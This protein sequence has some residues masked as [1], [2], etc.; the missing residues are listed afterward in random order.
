MLVKWLGFR[1]QCIATDDP[2]LKGN[3]G[4]RWI[5]QV[6]APSLPDVGEKLIREIYE[7]F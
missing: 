3:Q 2:R 7:I 6:V 5:V 4:D 1:L